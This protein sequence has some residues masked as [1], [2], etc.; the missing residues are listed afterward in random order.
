MQPRFAQ[1]VR[2]RFARDRRSA[3]AEASGVSSLTALERIA[4]GEWDAQTW[5]TN[6][7]DSSRALCVPCP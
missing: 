2:K 4:S 6:Q 3:S 7:A 5:Q 1:D